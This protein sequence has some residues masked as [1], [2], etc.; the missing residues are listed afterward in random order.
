MPRDLKEFKWYTENTTMISD[1]VEWAK[2]VNK[3][4][5]ELKAEVKEIK[6]KLLDKQLGEI[7]GKL[8]QLLK[9]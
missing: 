4:V 7:N 5:N 6:E 8:D 9:K 3:E 2:E 1:I